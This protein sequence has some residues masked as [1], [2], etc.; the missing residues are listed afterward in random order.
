MLDKLAAGGG[1]I[2]KA[3]KER[4]ERYNLTRFFSLLN[5]PDVENY[6]PRVSESIELNVYTLSKLL[7][8]Y[9]RSEAFTEVSGWSFEAEIYHRSYNSSGA[10]AHHYIIR[11]TRQRDGAVFSAAWLGQPQSLTLRRFQD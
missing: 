3:A 1:R 7:A 11:G 6:V 4:G 5:V 9:K 2:H 10:E 8:A